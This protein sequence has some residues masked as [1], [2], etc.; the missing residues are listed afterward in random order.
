MPL[1]L[2][3]SHF[4]GL[5]ARD[6][7]ND[8]IA[9]SHQASEG[10]WF[11]IGEIGI[12]SS[13]MPNCDFDN[14][15][16]KQRLGSTLDTDLAITFDATTTVDGTSSSGQK[17]VQVT[18]TTG[19]IAGR[20]VT[21]DR[22]NAN[23]ENIVIASISAGVSITAV[24]NLTNEHLATV[25]VEQRVLL[26][27]D[28][29]LHDGGHLWQSPATNSN[30]IVLASVKT[31]YIN[32][33]GAFVQINDS[34]SSPY[35]HA[36][37]ALD[38]TFA[39]VDGHLF[40]GLSGANQIQVYRTG[41]D[42][43]EEAVASNNYI[44]VF[45]GGTPNYNDT[46]GTG[47]SNVIGF[48]DRLLFNNGDSVIEYTAATQPYNRTNG[49]FFQARGAVIAMAT[50]TP[51]FTDSLQETL[52]I[53][54]LQGVEVVTGFTGSDDIQRLDAPSPMNHNSVIH[55]L[56]WLMYLSQEKTIIAINGAFFTNIGSRMKPHSGTSFLAG[57]NQSAAITKSFGYYDQDKNQA[58]WTAPTGTATDGTDIFVLDMKKGEPAIGEP[59]ESYER[60]INC[61]HWKIKSGNTWFQSIFKTTSGSLGLLES[62]KLY[63]TES[64]NNDLDTIAIESRWRMPD[65]HAGFPMNH[66]QWLV[67]FLRGLP[68]GTY[69]VTVRYHEDRSEA[70]FG[71]T[72][73]YSQDGG[74]S[75]FGTAVFG[76]AVYATTV[77]IKGDNDT[78]LYSELLSI[79]IE[80]LEAGETWKLTDAELHYLI[81]AQER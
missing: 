55:T 38:V 60:R 8:L 48:H 67:A 74:T 78:D 2:Q 18:A 79:S 40:I 80:N 62:G 71:A 42:L 37:D 34:A 43:D 58:M 59:P 4:G 51:Q 7:S 35:A 28:T 75:V 57:I 36:A 20:V 29:L 1:R 33:S 32:Q 49:G 64:G 25:A 46:W 53:F 3:I 63:T 6:S 30:I 5:N 17:V 23:E 39:E 65:F 54:T 26:N 52:Y 15:G 21:L 22:G 50:L 69:T 76:T 9:R 77:V 61:L 81:G 12:E 44:E 41:A 27:G 19:M 72:W 45:G 68:T 73:G 16:I 31:I 66:K 10:G 47:M 24:D 13:E 56:S 14:D 11:P 70:T